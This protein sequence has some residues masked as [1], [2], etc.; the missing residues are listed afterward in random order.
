VLIIL[1]A[2]ARVVEK[3]MVM[4]GAHNLACSSE[5]CGTM[6]LKFKGSKVANYLK[7]TL[8]AMDLYDVEFGKIWGVNYKVV[9]KVEGYYNDMLV[10]LF[11][12]TTGLY[13]KL[14]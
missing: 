13:T 7:I 2:A 6:M 5:G 11:E 4:V 12:E 3:F 1:P 14:F 10:R 9:K 8:T